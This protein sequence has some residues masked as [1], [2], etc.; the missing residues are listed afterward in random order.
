MWTPVS[1]QSRPQQQRD[2]GS[3]RTLYLCPPPHLLGLVLIDVLG[4]RTGKESLLNKFYEA[5]HRASLFPAF[6]QIYSSAVALAFE[7][8]VTPWPHLG[9]VSLRLADQ[10]AVPSDTPAVGLDVT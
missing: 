9:N 10:Q 7:D 5:R 3:R 6:A 2:T 4:E 1:S 8:R